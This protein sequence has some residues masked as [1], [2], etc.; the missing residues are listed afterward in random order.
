MEGRVLKR[1]IVIAIFLSILLGVGWLVYFIVKPKETCTDGIQNQ[2]E[3][4]IDCGRVCQNQCLR[5]ITT[6]D[7]E[8]RETAM[9]YGGPG[10]T[11]ALV[12]VRN[13]NDEAGASS[14]RYRI[15]VVGKNGETVA[16][17]GA[18]FILPQETKYLLEIGIPI[19][20]AESIRAVFS[21]YR[22]ERFTGYQEKPPFSVLNRRYEQVSSGTGFGRA[23]GIVRNDSTFDFRTIAI[24]VIL[25]D[26]NG[27]AIAFN[28]TVQNTMKSGESREFDLLWPTGFPGTVAR[29]ETEIE[30]DVFRSEN[31]LKQYLPNQTFQQYE[32]SQ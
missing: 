17:E 14:F 26:A 20:D 32:Y 31:F 29:V 25:R 12:S 23:F 6:N 22:W 15:E 3:E 5:P 30:A 1:I 18:S 28:R 10:K 21:E 24:K 11:D 7:L 4:G 27:K 2:R 16:R 19:V 13:P 8:V 9:V